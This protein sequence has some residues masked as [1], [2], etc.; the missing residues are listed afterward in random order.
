M[1]NSTRLTDQL[2]IAYPIVQA[3]MA[4]S[5]TPE[6]VAAISNEGG[7]G[8]I[9]AGYMTTDVLS[10]EIEAVR[11][12]TDKPFAV[13]LFVPEDI[14]Y[15]D[16]AIQM[17]QEKLKPYYDKY[18]LKTA[19]VKIHSEQTFL[20]KIQ[21][22]MDMEVPVVSFTFGIPAQQ[23]INLLKKKGIITIGTASSIEEARMIEQSGLDMVVAQGFEAGGHK[24]A[25]TK[26]RS[27]GTLALIPQIVDSVSLPVIAAGG[28]MDAR[29]ILASLM[30][31]ASGVQMGTAFLTTHESKA[32][33]D[34]KEA[35]IHAQ[36]EDTTVTKVFSGKSARG[37]ENNFI[38]D[39]ETSGTNILPYPLQND[40]TT[41]IRQSAA[42]NGDT[43]ILHMWC[44]QAPTLA[45]KINA[46]GL[47]REIVAH[48]DQLIL[49]FKM[50]NI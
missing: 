7:L 35:I 47:F 17:M 40:L 49:D 28:I 1:W 24:G 39:L 32:P 6:L 44:G 34:H 30:L 23:I 27:I 36:P 26:T 3:G 29:G 21:L 14:Q 25:F 13:N 12:L 8:T 43:A 2:S 11:K 38:N 50:N 41:S 15:D 20:D 5:T 45:K 4:G 42:K 22:L 46:Q 37:I 18:D 19:N 48:T 10:D 9:G 16:S 31:G 33:N